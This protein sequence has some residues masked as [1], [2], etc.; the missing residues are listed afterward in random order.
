MKTCFGEIP[1][2]RRKRN[3][4]LV[5]SSDAHAQV[6]DQT[7]VL[8]R[9]SGFNPFMLSTYFNNLIPPF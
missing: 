5:M 9:L 4:I 8:F 1:K 2:G 7:L 3:P 6:P